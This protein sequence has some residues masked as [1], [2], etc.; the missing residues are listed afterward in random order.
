[1]FKI[2]GKYWYLN[3]NDLTKTMKKKQTDIFTLQ[4]KLLQVCCFCLIKTILLLFDFYFCLHTSVFYE[5]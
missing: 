4:G 1:M 5:L 3:K 2:Q